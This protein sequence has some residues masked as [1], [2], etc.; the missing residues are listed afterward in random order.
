MRRAKA[1]IAI[2]LTAATA[3]PLIAYAQGYC[4]GDCPADA[5]SVC[6]GIILDGYCV[7]NPTQAQRD[8][9]Q[10]EQRAE[11]DRRERELRERQAREAEFRREVDAQLASMGGNPSRRAE[12]ERFV[13]MRQDAAAARAKLPTP[14]RQCTSRT[15]TQ[16]FTSSGKTRDAAFASM[17][18]AVA[19]KSGCNIGGS[20]SVLSMSQAT[21]A[22]CT[23]RTLPSLASVTLNGKYPPIGTCLACISETQAASLGWV[24]G[25]GWPA[26]E[27]EWV[28]TATVQC[29]AE[30]CGTGSSAVSA[31]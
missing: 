26:P 31:Q 21:A 30:R 7:D 16:P 12:A 17:T 9:Y 19:R 3:S 18:T 22:N 2:F 6:T 10:A 1:G 11:Q 28:C 4:W 15:W 13:K 14:P 24:K 25:K 23:E 5:I 29:A 20:E 27:K 8:R